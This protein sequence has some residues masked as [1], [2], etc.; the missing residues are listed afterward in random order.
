MGQAQPIPK[1]M[2]T[3]TPNLVLG[4]CAA[5]IEFYKRAF[6]AEELMRMPTPDGKKIWHAEL[7][8]GDSVVYLADE[9]PEG[10]IQ[11]P[12]PDYPSSVSIML[13][14][15]DADALQARA[16]RAGAKPAMSMQDMFW[17]D[18]MGSIGDPFGY[19]WTI[20]THVR[21]VSET[22]MRAAVERM[23]GAAAG[24]GG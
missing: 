16:V 10:G 20:A 12:T 2:H 19:V 14:V 5:A 13:Y 17:G 11:A 22:E 8:I 1:G 21:D 3:V 7:R 15:P 9:T 4:D 18:R 6:G 24:D 23:S